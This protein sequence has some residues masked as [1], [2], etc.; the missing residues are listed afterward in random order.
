LK[1]NGSKKSISAI[2]PVFVVVALI[3]V[4]LAGYY[5]ATVLPG[6][7]PTSATNTAVTYTSTLTGNF[8]SS[9]AAYIAIHSKMVN[10]SSIYIVPGASDARV[11]AFNPSPATVV[12]GVNNT[13][14]WR[15]EDS[16]TQNV[17]GANGLFNSSNMTALTGQF[18]YTFTTPG[19]YTYSSSLYSFENGTITVVAGS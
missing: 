18:S 17:V 3:L 14:V 9:S 8:T 12:I 10:F 19:T 15:N 7:L 13:V 1:K 11:P 2:L 5:V 6:S 16:V 4:I